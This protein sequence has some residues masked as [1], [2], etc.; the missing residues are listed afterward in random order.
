M[1]HSSEMK[2]LLLI[3]NCTLSTEEVN[4]TGRNIGAQAQ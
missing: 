3:S 4:E 2:L 1:Q